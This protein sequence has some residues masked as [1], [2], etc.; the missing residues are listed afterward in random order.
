MAPSD[1]EV[2]A[3]VKEGAS[4]P[5]PFLPVLRP[6][7]SLGTQFIEITSRE[8]GA[9]VHAGGWRSSGEHQ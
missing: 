3:A 1:K 4:K 5:R 6:C 8:G 9:A 2:K 7:E